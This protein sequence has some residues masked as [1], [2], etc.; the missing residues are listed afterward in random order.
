MNKRI[1]VSIAGNPNCGKSSLFNALTGLRQRTGNYPG[2]TVEKMSGVF[3]LG[4]REFDLVD[5]PG[6]YSLQARSPDEKVAADLIREASTE[7]FLYVADA[8]NLR[9]SLYLFMQMKQAGLPMILVL[10]MVD[11]SAKKGV[12]IDS[13]LL[14]ELLETPVVPFVARN[15]EGLR[16]LHAEILGFRKK[17]LKPI[18]PGGI[19][20]TYSKIDSVLKQVVTRS[21]GTGTGN[22]EKLDRVFLHPVFGYLI[23]GVILALM[24]QAIF[25]LASYP[26]EWIE[27]LTVRLS[28]YLSSVL[29]S[30][31]WNSLLTEG[32]IPGISG[33]IVFIP[34]IALLFF[35]LAILEE[36]GYMTRV[37]FLMDRIMRRIGLHGRSVVPLVSG[38]ACAIPAI[39]A[40]RTINN[41]RDRLITVLVIPLITCSARLPVFV[42]LVSILVP[43]GNVLG[44]FSYQGLTMAGL[45][46]GG[47]TASV[48]AAI[49]LSRSLKKGTELPFIMEMPRYK[50]P[51]WKNLLFD[52]Y[53]RSKS[54]V[55]GAGKI[56]VA[57]SVVL[58]FLSSFGPKDSAISIPEQK[59]DMEDSYAA[60]V[61]KSIEPAIIPLGYDW[62]IGI[63]LFTSF[64]ARE[65]FVGTMNTIYSI[66]QDDKKPLKEKLMSGKTD[67]GKPA[68]G[69]AT[70]ASLICFYFFALQC[71]STLVVMKRETGGWKWPVIQFFI[72]GLLAY[73][74]AFAA[75]RLFS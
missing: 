28:H 70:A 40:T 8:A 36:S 64:A 73:F 59:Q 56:I 41:S 38:A 19:A 42:L 72:F 17:E 47:L 63:A 50:L 57:V 45:Y 6:L 18:L 54:F 58:W 1:Q 37:T 3:R 23:F 71:I 32:I 25:S 12:I 53:T 48:I 62:K 49:V 61:G 4:Q 2:V 60:M 27:L 52:I 31:L 10:N 43:A 26:M 9:R 68:F 66:G 35:F 46:F 30:G 75:F 20:E 55:V 13:F 29:P 74:S 51:E 34:Q 65:V 5:L 33:V 67:T 21:S 44:I 15:N 16:R 24:F 11:L 69:K 39:M 7:L 22:G 14:G